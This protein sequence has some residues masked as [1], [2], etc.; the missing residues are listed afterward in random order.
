MQAA[1]LEEISSLRWMA[2]QSIRIKVC[3]GSLVWVALNLHWARVKKHESCVL[4]DNPSLRA[5]EAPW[6]DRTSTAIRIPIKCTGVAPLTSISAPRAS[7]FVRM[8]LPN[9]AMEKYYFRVPLSKR[10]PQK[11]H[12]VHIC[13]FVIASKMG[14]YL[15]DQ[16]SPQRSEREY[17]VIHV[18]RWWDVGRQT[19]Y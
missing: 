15:T 14:L 10:F 7:W 9:S 18:V 6:Q 2:G 3:W 13:P 8:L 12:L 16:S 5:T 1:I 4:T 19:C 11:N 17:Y